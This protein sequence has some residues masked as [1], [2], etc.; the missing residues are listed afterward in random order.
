MR[1][2]R[3]W[4][5]GIGL[6]HMVTILSCIYLCPRVADGRQFWDVQELGLAYKALPKGSVGRY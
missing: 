6:L 1:A 3:V 4:R 5:A 2:L